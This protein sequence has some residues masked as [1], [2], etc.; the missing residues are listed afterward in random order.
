MG[1]V[2]ERDLFALS[3]MSV[4]RIGA[5]LRAAQ[6]E[7]EL[8]D[9]APRIRELARHLGAQ[10]VGARTL[11]ALIAHLNDL[12]TERLVQIHAERLDLDLKQAAWLAFGS[13]GRGE[14][15]LATDQ[16]N[17]IV[18]RS[19]NPEL[20]R[21]RWLALGEAVCASLADCGFPLCKGGVMASQPACC[22]SV[23][24]WCERF[25]SWLA[26]GTPEELLAASIYFDARALAGATELADPLRARARGPA[27]ARFLH[28]LTE[29]ALR[30]K[31][32]LSWRGA[33]DPQTLNGQEGLDLKAGGTAV[34][35]E[36]A[37]ILALSQGLEALGTRERL[38][39]AGEAL[40]V[41]APEREGWTAAFEFLQGLRLRAH[42][43][44][45]ADPE[46]AN[47]VPMQALNDL[48]R[49]TLRV[50]LRVAQRLQQRL[51][52][53]FLKT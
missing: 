38:L 9:L 29:A 44:A 34:F 46:N 2:S 50:S 10:G 15:T 22:A 30:G 32:P 5:D 12:L 37:R 36:A 42:M 28:L 33:L 3:R 48:D 21:P 1:I 41:A 51:Q 19:D 13:E 25:Q 6:D 8:R 16:D 26:R 53:E 27:G 39:R 4:Q 52:M 40:G 31:V 47:W 14:Q 43:E 11:T 7:S 24:E 49:R 35:V 17:G 20:D 23:Q 18:F 45:Q